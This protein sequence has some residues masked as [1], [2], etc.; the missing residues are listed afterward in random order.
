[1]DNQQAYN[2][3]ADQYDTNSNCTR[4]LEAIALRDVL[5]KI[6]FSKVLEIGCGTGKNS[7]W[8]VKQ[9]EQVTAVDFSE[10]MLN[11][12]KAKVLAP[13]IKFIQADITKEWS[14]TNETF[15]LVTF[16][17][18]LEHIE[19][20]DF[21]F[22]EARTKI[23]DNGYLYIGELHPFK[24]YSGSLARFD[25]NNESVELQ[26][27]THHVSEF[28]NAASVN[29]FTLVLLNEWFDDANKVS[30]PRILTLLFKVIQ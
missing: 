27:F 15:D 11:K 8:L 20:I 17:L 3:W 21:I 22:R 26:C 18:V 16:S 7:E 4:D 6:Q 1:M 10:E 13:N 19:D 2:V 24:Q 12:A 29:G 30:I 9:S 25:S 5:G 28:L 14:F 23:A